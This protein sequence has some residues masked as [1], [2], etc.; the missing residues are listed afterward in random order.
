MDVLAVREG[1]NGYFNNFSAEKA[2]LKDTNYEV[3]RELEPLSKETKWED[4]KD[5]PPTYPKK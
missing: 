3:Y 1:R 4:C 5:C 2:D